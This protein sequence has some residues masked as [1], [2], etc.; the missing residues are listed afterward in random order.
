MSARY[1]RIWRLSRPGSGVAKG[2]SYKGR[3]AMLV[4]DEPELLRPPASSRSRVEK[5]F[6][7]DGFAE[8]FPIGTIHILGPAVGG[9]SPHGF[10]VG[11]HA[12]EFAL[13]IS[14]RPVIPK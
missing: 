3:G 6:L 5:E 11:G 13:D 7:P 8:R 12:D 14:F 2:D 4:E 10:T 1:S 9:E